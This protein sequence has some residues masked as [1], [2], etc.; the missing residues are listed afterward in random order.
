MSNNNQPFGL[1]PWNGAD[2]GDPTY[3]LSTRRIPFNGGAIFRGDPVK[4]LDTG[5][6]AL[7]TTG[8][9][10]SQLAGVFWGCKYYSSSRQEMVFGKY[11][12]GA[13]VSATNIVTAFIIPIQTAT[14][15]MFVAQ[16]A[17]SNTT[18]TAVGFADIGAN[19][20]VTVGT[21]NVINGQSTTYIDQYNSVNHTA[22]TL[23]FRMVNYYTGIGPGS[24]VASAYNW[25]IVQANI[26]QETGI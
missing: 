17:N 20:D 23:P 8:T 22:A 4:N 11:W 14:P 12:P 5:N 2:L 24:D 6:I 26:Y 7:W 18:A 13:D 16:T 19:F 15:P 10:V 1:L 3:G 21:G 9:A 25:V